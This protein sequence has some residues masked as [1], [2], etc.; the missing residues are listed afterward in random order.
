MIS[1]QEGKFATALRTS[2]SFLRCSVVILLFSYANEGSYQEG[3]I[4]ADS[5]GGSMTWHGLLI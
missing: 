1:R 2:S 5:V 3:W 4:L